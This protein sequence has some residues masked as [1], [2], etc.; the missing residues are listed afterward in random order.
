M[1]NESARSEEDQ[2]HDAGR[3]R[4]SR[5]SKQ[6]FREKTIH[7]RRVDKQPTGLKVTTTKERA[8]AN[9]KYKTIGLS[10]RFAIQTRRNTESAASVYASPLCRSSS[11]PT[12]FLQNSIHSCGNPVA[13]LS[14]LPPPLQSNLPSGTAVPQ[15]VRRCRCRQD[16]PKTKRAT[17]RRVGCPSRVLVTAKMVSSALYEVRPVILVPSLRAPR[18]PHTGHIKAYYHAWFKK[19]QRQT[20]S[21]SVE[22]AWPAGGHDD[23]VSSWWGT[24]TTTALTTQHAPAPSPEAPKIFASLG[25]HATVH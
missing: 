6:N 18:L 15:H 24:T 25:R 14:R 21:A 9:E 23:A 16:S 3:R 1:E 4:P 11:Y 20:V 13:P 8:K 19:H 7:E 22:A 2:R 5:R 10:C 12:R 17:K